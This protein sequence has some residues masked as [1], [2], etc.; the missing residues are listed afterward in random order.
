[1]EHTVEL[2]TR[3]VQS[4]IDRAELE[5]SKLDAHHIM[6]N[7]MSS[8]KIRH[9]LNNLCAFKG[10]EYFEVGCY[11][12]STLMAATYMNKHI[13][14]RGIDN[15]SE[16]VEHNALSILQPRVDSRLINGYN[17]RLINS[18]FFNWNL[19]HLD[20]KPNVYFYDGPQSYEEQFKAIYFTQVC[21][22]PCILIVDDW[23]ETER[24]EK[25]TRDAMEKMN[26]KVHKEWSLPGGPTEWHCGFYIAVIE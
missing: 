21:A 24:V 7:G 17:V 10:C 2:Y 16:F 9:F 26:I 4:S 3:L 22:K 12:G 14:A 20:I 19:Y 8:P 5:L 23:G 11:E 13:K 1:M 15:F 6:M 18:D 25:G